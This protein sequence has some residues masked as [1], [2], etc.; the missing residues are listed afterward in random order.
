MRV[1]GTWV[2]GSTPEALAR[3][4]SPSGSRRAVGGCAAPLAGESVDPGPAKIAAIV[5]MRGADADARLRGLEARRAAARPVLGALA[6]AFLDGRHFEALGY[7]CVG[8]WSRERIGV[9]ARTLR[10]W[11][12]VWRGLAELPRM[13]AAV[14]AGEV[15]WTVARRA[16]RHVTRENEAECVE[17]L[18]G[19][20]V[21][22]AEAILAAYEAANEAANEAE[23]VASDA[24]IEPTEGDRVVVRLG[25]SPRSAAKWAEALELARR[26]AGEALPVW[27]CAEA[28]AAEGASAWGVGEL[29]ETAHA[30]ETANAK[31]TANVRGRPVRTPV[32]GHP[33]ENGLR[34]VAWPH[35]R[36]RSP[37]PVA[38]GFL[39]EIGEGLQHCDAQ[40]LDARF[41]RV[42]ASLQ[43]VDFELGR[44]L[45]QVLERRLH[46]ELGFTSFER[47]V[48]ER[49][50]LSGRTARRMVALAR[51]EH[52]APA[53]ASAFREGRVHAFQGQVLLRATEREPTAEAQSRWVAHA[54]RVTLRR[55]EDD[56]GATPRTAI[57]FTAPREVAELFLAMVA[58]AGG[59]EALLDHAIATWLEAGRAFRDYADFER[60]GWRCT[61]PGC[62]A[63][64]N[65]QSHHIRF[66]SAGGPDVPWNRTTLCASHHQRG[67]HEGRIAIRIEFATDDRAPGRPP[68]RAPGRPPARAPGG[69]PTRAP[70]S[71]PTSA[72]T[73]APTSA[74]TSAPTTITGRAPD[75]L[76]YTLGSERYRSG[77]LR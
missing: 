48:S 9:G 69:A 38:N 34:E 36:W 35:L 61:V 29:A 67:V 15:S 57:A 1:R 25:A 47:Y 26:W 17:T 74:P 4:A 71:A 11:A 16:L 13:R 64:R 40:Q 27:G 22:A 55:L 14:L 10:E 32:A 28:I 20:T 63:R 51:A 12:R 2:A 31:E 52:R 24:F 37:A 56:A 77:D 45:R 66:R 23:E 75:G 7:R 73:R 21:R 53:V 39:D 68:A 30:Q 50:D 43:E 3:R 76:I 5:A 65:L 33:E 72:P 62:T 41:R 19:R 46:L 18:R 8:D 6:V 49:L 70:T 59:L 42:V 44:L 58:R 60:D 54:A